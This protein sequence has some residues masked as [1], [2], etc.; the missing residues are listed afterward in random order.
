MHTH[1]NT[2]HLHHLPLPIITLLV[3]KR[4]WQACFKFILSHVDWVNKQEQRRERNL[5]PRWGFWHYW[6]QIMQLSQPVIRCL[7]SCSWS[8]SPTSFIE[9]EEAWEIS[10]KCCISSITGTEGAVMLPELKISSFHFFEYLFC[11]AKCH[12]KQHHITEQNWN[13]VNEVLLERGM[14][15][16]LLILSSGQSVFEMLDMSTIEIW[17]LLPTVLDIW[18]YWNRMTHNVCFKQ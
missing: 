8:P 11:N 16:L 12:K 15:L 5:L 2:H 13:T 18:C 1:T 9:R 7:F 4:N 6:E 17:Q 3:K 14:E 10:N